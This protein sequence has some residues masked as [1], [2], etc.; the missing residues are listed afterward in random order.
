MNR[1]FLKILLFMILFSSVTFGIG[2]GKNMFSTD[3]SYKRSKSD[4]LKNK[5]SSE[6]A[7]EIALNHARVSKNN[8]KF[9]K[10]GLHTKKDVLIYKIEFYVDKT[11]YQYEIDA[12]NGIILKTKNNHKNK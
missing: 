10:I 4:D 3:F 2:K 9:K 11:R 1:K 5:I 6:K 12:R 7:K 8:A